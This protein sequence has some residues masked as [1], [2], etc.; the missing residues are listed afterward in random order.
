[1][2]PAPSAAP[3]RACAAIASESR[4]S[5]RKFP[6]LQHNLMRAQRRGPEPGGHRGRRDEAGLES[7][8]PHNAGRAPAPA[9]RAARLR[10]GTQRHPF[11][12]QRPAEQQRGQPLARPGWPPPSRP[13]SSRGNP[14]QP[15]TSSGHSSAESPNPASTYRSG[16]TVSCT[17]RS[18]PLPASDTRIAGAPRIAIRS[19]GIAASGDVAPDRRW[20]TP[21]APPPPAPQRRSTRPS[22]APAR[23]PGRLP[24][25]RRLP[26]SGAEI[27]GR[28]RRR[29]I[30][31]K[32]QMRN[33]PAPRISPPMA[34]PA[35]LNAPSRPT[36]AVSNSK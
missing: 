10:F 18:Q 9:G 21:A 3:T 30:G 36:T 4:T 16:R 32:R 22:P 15:N 5:A 26:V 19:H 24:P 1:M 8:R 27:A 31:Q 35:R 2:R 33:R 6:E 14:S 12:A 25:P 23:S 34:S 20:P 17:P 28:T 7:Q 11:G 29:A 13:D